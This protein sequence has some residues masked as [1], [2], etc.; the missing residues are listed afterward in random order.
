MGESSDTESMDTGRGSSSKKPKAGD[1]GNLASTLAFGMKQ[2]DEQKAREFLYL[3]G[4]QQDKDSMLARMRE[5]AS[6]K[7]G[8]SDGGSIAAGGGGSETT[9]CS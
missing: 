5:I 1:D 2:Q 3:H 7:G 8:D 9:Y 6:G 4:T